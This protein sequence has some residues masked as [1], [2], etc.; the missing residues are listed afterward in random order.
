[1]AHGDDGTGGDGQDLMK[2]QVT[3]MTPQGRELT[4]TELHPAW[5]LKEKIQRQRMEILAALVGTRREQWKKQAAT[6]QIE[7]KDPSTEQSA[8][9][10]KLTKLLEQ[11]NVIDVETKEV[12]VKETKEDV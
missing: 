4:R 1:L 2:Q 9:T 12:E 10:G 8:L 6:K 3:G 11:G 7:N 5:E